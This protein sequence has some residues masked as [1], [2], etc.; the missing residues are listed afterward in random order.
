MALTPYFFRKLAYNQVFENFNGTVSSLGSLMSGHQ[1]ASN[2]TGIRILTDKQNDSGDY[3]YLYTS[4]GF[5]FTVTPTVDKKCENGEV[6]LT[7]TITI[8]NNGAEAFTITRVDIVD[9][10]YHVVEGGTYQVTRTALD[11]TV[12]DSPV[13]VE[14]NG[15]IGQVVYTIKFRY[16][17]PTA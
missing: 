1:T 17:E 11:Q 14:A 4:N 3:L 6:I 9:S 12:L 2:K 13:T 16:E 5:A 7:S 8:V 15:G 10:F